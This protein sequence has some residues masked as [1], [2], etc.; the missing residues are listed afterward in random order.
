MLSRKSGPPVPPRPKPSAVALATKNRENSP[1]LQSIQHGRT[2]IYKSPSMILNNNNDDSSKSISYDLKK[3]K[4]DININIS[5]DNENSHSDDIK[6]KSPVPRPRLNNN[7]NN[8]NRNS[9]ENTTKIDESNDVKEGLAE[10]SKEKSFI[11][12][13]NNM[14]N[15]NHVN[16]LFTEII[17]NSSP[18]VEAK[19][20]DIKLEHCTI[21]VSPANNITSTKYNLL[22]R[23]EPEGGEFIINPPQEFKNS[24]QIDKKKVAFHEIL[25][26]ELT[27]MRKS[28]SSNSYDKMQKSFDISPNGTQRSRIRT[29]DWV[30]VGDNGK[31]LKL[32]SCQISL[33]DSGLED[34]ERIDDCSSGVGDSWD[35]SVKDIDERYIKLFNFRD[36]IILFYC[37]I[38]FFSL[39]YKIIKTTYNR[40]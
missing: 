20:N 24:T 15:S 21:S 14:K 7:N 16:K 1:P 33:E 10:Q 3:S 37:A 17:I 12:I 39:L 34:E 5:N 11:E 36:L 6:K 35:S 19:N 38:F 8:N 2:V 26:S 13:E 30:E 31:E 23:P 27:A 40:L 25:I 28:G 32:S 29:A 22:K 4:T 9:I 18:I